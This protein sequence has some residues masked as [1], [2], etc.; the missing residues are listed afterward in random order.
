MQGPNIRKNI[1]KETC[2]FKAPVIKMFVD[3]TIFK[4]K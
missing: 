1:V 3:K 4:G 2:I